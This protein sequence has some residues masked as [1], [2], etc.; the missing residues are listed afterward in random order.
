MNT[1]TLRTL[2]TGSLITIMPPF[3]DIKPVCHDRHKTVPDFIV[4]LCEQMWVTII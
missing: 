1:Q 3:G 2:R 4:I